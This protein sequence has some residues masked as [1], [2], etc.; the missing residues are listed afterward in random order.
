PLL[1]PLVALL[2]AMIR[3]T[4]PAIYGQ[5]RIGK[6]GKEFTV[7]KFRTMVEHADAVL[8]RRLL[9]DPEL[10]AEWIR[11]HKLRHDPR[12]TT[13]GRI[14]RRTSLDELPQV[15]NVLLGEMSLVG[16]RPIV[17][18]ERVKY[19]AKLHVFCAVRPGLTGLWQVSG[20]N[21]L[22]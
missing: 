2:W 5:R 7:W 12:V 3:I 6:N 10:M 17:S 13:I 4:G 18:A 16:P 19:G 1:L 20:R 21:D 22:A 9:E 11:D 8:E 15:W 14:L